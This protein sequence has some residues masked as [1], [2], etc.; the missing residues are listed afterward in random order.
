MLKTILALI[1]F[2]IIATSCALLSIMEPPTDVPVITTTT[3]VGLI[4]TAAPTSTS[5]STQPTIAHPTRVPIHPTLVKLCPEN[6]MV[7]LSELGLSPQTRLLVMPDTLETQ[8]DENGLGVYII[9]PDDPI[10]RKMEYLF[11]DGFINSSWVRVSPNGRWLIL[12]RRAI[13][14]ET[15]VSWISSLD[16]QQQWPMNLPGDY[17]VGDW[18]DNE[19]VVVYDAQPRDRF[20]R[21][22]RKLLNPF[23]MEEES[24]DDL[25]ETQISGIGALLFRYAGH[26]FM[27]YQAGYD[28]RLF[29]VS[30]H[31]DRQVLEWL[32]LEPVPFLDKS[33]YVTTE[34]QIVIKV[35]R[36][37]GFDMSSWLDVDEILAS[38]SYM[39]TMQAVMVPQEILPVLPS[40]ET[41]FTLDMSLHKIDLQDP[42]QTIPWFYWFD[43]Q[44]QVV[45][46]YCFA[47]SGYAK[48]SSDNKF[49]AFTYYHL[50]SQAPAPK[51]IFVLN[52]ET[53]YIARID[54][55][56]FVGWA[57]ASE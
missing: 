25:P 31:T 3:E 36:P 28:Y 32:S 34:G 40:L 56:Q 48:L 26:T 22:P 11:Q 12:D 2:S 50:P 8:W 41:T 17:V 53:G 49:M 35:M 46:D 21:Q 43:Y 24:L 57:W 23:T 52:L 10:P 42:Q 1:I 54:G 4:Q 16:G 19:T 5:V 15:H 38:K 7:P 51:S 47:M 27:L 55:Y 14:Q 37:Y 29:D 18:L 45:K 13:G 44:R 39:Q 9:V 20:A 30:T 6:P 33:I